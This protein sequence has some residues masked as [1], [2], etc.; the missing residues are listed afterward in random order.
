MPEKKT[1]IVTGADRGIGAGLVEGFLK[2]DYNVVGTSRRVSQSLAPSA[3]LVLVDGDIGNQETAFK[4]VDAAVGRF[5]RIDVLVNNAGIFRKKAF[6][7]Y[8]TDDFNDL[9]SANLLGFLYMTQLAVKQMLKQ[10][11]GCVVTISAALA[12]QPFAGEPAS[13]SMLTKGGLNTITRSLAIEY[14]KEG[15]RFNA[16]APG[17][18]DTWLHGNDPTEILESY[19]PMGKIVK[20][21]DIVEAVLFLAGAGQITGEVLHVDGGEHAGRW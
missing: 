15:I 2:G 19:Q 8:T 9:A 12:D 17:V 6:T 11:S 18:V 1:A 13:V 16:V 21:S 4:T 7:D 10:K 3:S 5:G 20:V 14:A